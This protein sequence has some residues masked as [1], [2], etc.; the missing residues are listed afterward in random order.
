MNVNDILGC[1]SPIGRDIASSARVAALSH[2]GPL[3]HCVEQYQCVWRGVAEG[4][5]KVLSGGGVR[6]SRLSGPRG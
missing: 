2:A 1:I 3:S 4:E 5:R 6:T